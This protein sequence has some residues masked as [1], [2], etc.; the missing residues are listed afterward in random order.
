MSSAPPQRLRGVV[1]PHSGRAQRPH[2]DPRGRRCRRP[3]R[4]R[5]RRRPPKRDL[6]ACPP[7]DPP[8]H[9]AR[10]HGVK[11]PPRRRRNDMPPAARRARNQRFAPPQPFERRA[12]ADDLGQHV[13]GEAPRRQR[14]RS[15]APRS[16]LCRRGASTHPRSSRRPSAGL[17]GRVRR[18]RLGGRPSRPRALARAPGRQVAVAAH[19]KRWRGRRRPPRKAAHWRPRARSYG[20]AT[21]PHPAPALSRYF[22]SCSDVAPTSES[23]RLR[24]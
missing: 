16:S 12:E 11:E 17:L 13:V 10:A 22:G 3:R 21:W 2:R 23:S 14:V 1:S 18:G 15:A 24:L 4:A 19:A 20:A 7:A 9:C 5:S 8:S 6:V